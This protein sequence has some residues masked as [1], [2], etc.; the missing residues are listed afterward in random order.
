[1]NLYVHVY[2]TTADTLLEQSLQLII[3]KCV[4]PRQTGRIFEIATVSGFSKNEIKECIGDLKK[5]NITVRNF[6]ETVQQLRKKL[7]LGDSGDTY[8]FATTLA[9]ERKVLVK[10][11]KLK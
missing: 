4:T 11:R 10:C 7:K 9:D 8:L 6:P 5:A 2:L 3:Q 1:M